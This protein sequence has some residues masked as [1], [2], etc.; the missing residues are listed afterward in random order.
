VANSNKNVNIYN[1]STHQIVYTYS[2]SKTP[3]SVKFS[4]N[5]AFIGIAFDDTDVVIL[6]NSPPF[7]V[8]RTIA[9]GVSNTGNPNIAEIDFRYDSTEI[10]VCGKDRLKTFSVSTGANI[11]D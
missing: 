9:T 8:Y 2:N 6:N 1:A 7:S 5:S 3:T 11:L 10:L 4:K